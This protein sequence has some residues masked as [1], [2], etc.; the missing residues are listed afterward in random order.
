MGGGGGGR[1]PK[2]DG[3][4]VNGGVEPA[5]PEPRVEPAGD[6]DKLGLL[7]LFCGGDDADKGSNLEFMRYAGTLYCT[8]GEGNGGGTAVDGVPDCCDL[9]LTGVDGACF[10]GAIRSMSSSMSSDPLNFGIA[11]RLRRLFPKTA[12]VFSERPVA[13][14]SSSVIFGAFGTGSTMTW[15]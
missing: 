4:L 10:C 11:P 9:T 3:F 8:V 15:G 14:A 12:R 5:E 6:A 1:L 2:I 7:L 13:I